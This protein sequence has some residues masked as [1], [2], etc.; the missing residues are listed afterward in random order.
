[1]LNDFYQTRFVVGAQVFLNKSAFTA[2]VY[3]QV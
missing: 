2:F 3:Y 1:M